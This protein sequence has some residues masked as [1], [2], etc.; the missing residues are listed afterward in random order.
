MIHHNDNPF[1]KVIDKFMK[2]KE[3]Y[4]GDPYI[5]LG[6]KLKKIQMPKGVWC[7]SLSPS[8]Y[9]QEAVRNC[10]KHLK[11]NFA[12]EY[13]LTKNAPNPFPLGYE[14]E[15]DVSPLL[16]DD[17]ASYFQ[18]VMRV[19]RWMI[20][21]GRID[22]AVEVSMLSSFLAMPRNGHML[23]ALFIMSYLKVRHNSRICL[24]PTYPDIDQKKF[25]H[26]ANWTAFYGDVEEAIP[27]IAPKPLGKGVDLRM[28]V[29]S[30]H[31]RD[32]TNRRSRTGY[33]IFLNM[34]LNG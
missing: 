13:D 6:A 3:G 9:I 18:T 5:Y 29:N 25:M 23:A 12:D 4:V 26:A 14:A 33:L 1:L 8:R 28:F 30:D 19:M 11:E 24:D 2:L 34:D 22:I 7:W 21:L 10:K 20:E 27:V 31:T 17:K 16:P 32:K 15:T